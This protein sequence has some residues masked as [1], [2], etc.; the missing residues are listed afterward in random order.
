M[1]KNKPLSMFCLC[2]ES[3]REREREEDGNESI[4]GESQDKKRTY[5]YS[6]LNR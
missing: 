2:C 6:S 4:Y 1:W 3:E 5:I